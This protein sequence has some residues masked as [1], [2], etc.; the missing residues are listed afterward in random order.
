[1]IYCSQNIISPVFI[2]MITEAISLFVCFFIY[3]LPNIEDNSI[4]DLQKIQNM[5][6][7]FKIWKQIKLKKIGMII[8]FF[9]IHK[10]SFISEMH[11]SFVFII[12]V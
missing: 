2:Q 10:S 4:K 3:V 9:P 7:Y 11:M 12:S 8:F 6:K 1:M 5:R